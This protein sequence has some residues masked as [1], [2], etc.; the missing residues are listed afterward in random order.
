MCAAA[1]NAT[2]LMQCDESRVSGRALSNDALLSYLSN[3]SNAL[4]A[5]PMFEKV[6]R[7][8]L[9]AEYFYRRVLINTI[10]NHEDLDY[11]Y[12]YR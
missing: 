6:S 9:L 1:I 4:S 10:G 12:E 11:Y 2:P 8:I 5:Q 3:L 7:A